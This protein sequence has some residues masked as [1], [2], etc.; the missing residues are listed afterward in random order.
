MGNTI[1]FIKTLIAA[2]RYKDYEKDYWG[3]CDLVIVSK[4]EY[5]KRKDAIEQWKNTN[6]NRHLIKTE[7]ATA[8]IWLIETLKSYINYDYLSKYDYYIKIANV[9]EKNINC[10][11]KE[12]LLLILKELE[13]DNWI[14]DSISGFTVIES[15][16]KTWL[17][18]GMEHN[19]PFFVKF[20]ALWFAFN[21]EY[22][23]FPGNDENG[24][25]DIEYAKI[26]EFCENYMDKLLSIYDLVF[27]SPFI[28]IFTEKPVKD[29][30]KGFTSKHQ[31]KYCRDLIYGTHEEKTIA[32]FQIMYQ[33]RC[34][35]F[36]GGKSPNIDRDLDLVRYSGEIL[37]IY[38]S[39][40][41]KKDIW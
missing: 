39:V 25:S 35:L 16:L 32:I 12:L 2:E 8:I 20:M 36:H 7:I 5:K 3:E 28:D 40:V 26:K 30:K 37:E 23:R 29:M 18:F 15:N 6:L 31:K 9:I 10:S 33:V 22:N 38:L 4:N 27:K 21:Q 1:D 17:D 14:K 11:D 19:D 41:M 24:N 34:N 13:S